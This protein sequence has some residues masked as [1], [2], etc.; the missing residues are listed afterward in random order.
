MEPTQPGDGQNTGASQ[1]LSDMADN[2]KNAATQFGRKAGDRIEETR[3]A[4]ASRL[5]NTAETLHNKVEGASVVAHRAAD[6]VSAMGNYLDE[7][8]VKEMVTDVKGAMSRNPGKTLVISLIA[9]IL[10]GKAFRGDRD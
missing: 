5:R 9:G 3:Q 8:S 4:T 2:V 7:H 1:Q 6:K 10:V